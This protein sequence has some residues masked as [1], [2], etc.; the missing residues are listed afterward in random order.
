MK[1]SPGVRF[2][3]YMYVLWFRVSGLVVESACG[4]LRITNQPF[5]V[6]PVTYIWHEMFYADSAQLTDEAR[7]WA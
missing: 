4:D 5:F 6:D 2:V 7:F 1:I 3:R